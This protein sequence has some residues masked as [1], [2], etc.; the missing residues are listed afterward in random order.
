MIGCA[1]VQRDE[2]QPYNAGRVHCKS[3][4]RKRNISIGLRNSSIEIKVNV[5]IMCDYYTAHYYAGQIISER[6]INL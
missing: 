4:N 2:S 5:D 3:C 6:S 1:E